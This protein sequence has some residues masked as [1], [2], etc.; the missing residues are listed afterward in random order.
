M[1]SEG[2]NVMKWIGN[3][4]IFI[5]FLLAYIVFVLHNTNH[6]NM[7]DVEKKSGNM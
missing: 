5:P 4:E 6:S 3:K 7:N 1:D 2:M